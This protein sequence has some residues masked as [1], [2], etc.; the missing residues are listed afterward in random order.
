M[1]IQCE[2]IEGVEVDTDELEEGGVFICIAIWV[3]EVL[4]L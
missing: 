2:T 3:V 1:G 4:S